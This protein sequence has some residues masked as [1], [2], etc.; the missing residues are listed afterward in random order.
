MALGLQLADLEDVVDQLAEVLD[1]LR[2]NV[3]D[4]PIEASELIERM[5]SAF[6]RPSDG[7]SVLRAR[8]QR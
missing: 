7:Q 4:G 5:E 6:V 1:E 2:A 8:E 3:G